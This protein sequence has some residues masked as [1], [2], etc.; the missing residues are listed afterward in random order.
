M[1][2]SGDSGLRTP[3]PLFPFRVRAAFVL[4]NLVTLAALVSW[5]LLLQAGT[6]SQ[7]DFYLLPGVTVIAIIGQIWLL[8]D[9]RQVNVVLGVWLVSV[10]GYEL[11]DL[12]SSFV[13]V[14]RDSGFL[15]HGTLWFM[16]VT[17]AA[18]IALPPK[19]ALLFSVGYNLIAAAINLAAFWANVSAQQVNGILQF[20]AA[21]IAALIVL[22][23]LSQ[24]QTQYGQMER[25]SLTDALT[26]L[27]NRRSLEMRLGRATHPYCAVMFDVDHFK[28]IND[29]HGH[30][31]GDEV[32]RE[33]AF[34]L[35]N[36]TPTNSSLARWGGEEFL[37]LLPGHTGPQALQV[38]ATLCWAV[39][40]ARPGGLEVTL[41]AGVSAWRSGDAVKNVLE[42]ADEALYRVKA[43]GRNRATLLE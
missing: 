37:L 38:A 14:M 43:S 18:F 25:L 5:G 10:A 28:R 9:A 23:A 7:T 34:T 32:L 36:H 3:D 4:L 40:K 29:T 20:H 26:G 8:V 12:A 33:I 17:I 19:A 35:S 22:W 1:I 11:L 31:F 6:I 16:V 21:N 27:L 15:A 13:T 41:S 2:A 42:R 39:A 30:A 24:L